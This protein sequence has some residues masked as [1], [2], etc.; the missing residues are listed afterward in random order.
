MTN[1]PVATPASTNNSNVNMARSAISAFGMLSKPDPAD[2]AIRVSEY[3]QI[4]RH[5]WEA[6]VLFALGRTDE[7]KANAK[8]LKEKSHVLG[9]TL[10]LALLRL[11]GDQASFRQLAE[12]YAENTGNSPAVW[13]EAHEKSASTDAA[14]NSTTVK[15]SSLLTERILETTMRMDTSYPLTL[16]FE[17]VTEVDSSGVDIFHE[18][19]TGRISRGESTILLSTDKLAGQI[20]KK[21]RLDN[22]IGN[23]EITAFL[24][25]VYRM[26]GNQHDFDELVSAGTKNDSS[27]KPMWSDLRDRALPEFFNVKE[28]RILT[29]G[30]NIGESLAIVNPLLITSLQSNE[31]FQNSRQHGQDFTLDFSKVNRWT[32]TDM[33]GV[34]QFLRQAETI[35]ISL[36]FI[37]VN[38]ILLA[39]FKAFGIDKSVKL[40]VDGA[41]AF[42]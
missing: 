16:D 3:G 34:L 7:V 39:L 11:D 18:S 27:E 25:D 1:I 21:I 2:Q 15:I 5:M 8:A 19:L 42:G 6:N 20:S 4:D 35:K 26:T 24:L 17:N 23:P 38:E 13:L 31:E 9:Y 12:E 30:F 29:K 41:A 14:I 10:T 22:Y 33:S 28:S 36:K 40:V 37:N 32:F